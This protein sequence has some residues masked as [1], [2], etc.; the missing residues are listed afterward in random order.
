MEKEP[1]KVLQVAPLGAGGVTSLILNIA[2]KLD[3]RKVKFDYLTFYDRTE[4]NE[5]RACANGSKKYVVP[6]DH[7]ANPIIRAIYKFFYS[8]VIIKKAK[9]DIIHINGS[10]P[11][12]V[13]VGV[14]A[15]FAGV[16]TV[17][18][19]S[20]NS[21]MS[22]TS[23]VKGL[24]MSALKLFIPIAADYYFACSELAAQFM[25]PKSIL[26]KKNY[27]IIKNAIDTERYY[28]SEQIRDEYRKKLNIENKIAIAHIGRFTHQK[29]HKFLIDIFEKV[30]EKN[31]E[32]VLVLI[33]MGEL[34]DDVKAYVQK[35][36]L[37]NS[38]VLYGTS[39]EVPQLLQ[40]FDCFLMPS[41]YEGLPVVGVEVQA[42]GLPTILSD[43]ITKEVAITD[44]VK[45][46]SLD[47]SEEEWADIVLDAVEKV[48]DR[49][50]Y[51][52]QVKKAGFDVTE[53]ANYLMNFYRKIL[54]TK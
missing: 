28:F 14:A 29:N 21:S 53:T 30:H 22:Q 38:V 25:F 12:D 46:V 19:H 24:L 1:I 42:A 11:Y 16:K 45:Y 10:K 37:E 7:F 36:K 18:F 23:G 40:A 17:I 5:K 15:K 13:L 50:L 51:V 39:S 26:N 52:E 41:F 6:I 32:T 3:D 4:F 2:E 31:S 54:G 35:K 27:T 20:H 47:K 34:F 48:K 43:T 8:I 44:L 49:R 9:A 33:G